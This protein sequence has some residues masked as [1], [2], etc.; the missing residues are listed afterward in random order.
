MWEV[1]WTVLEELI[2]ARREGTVGCRGSRLGHVRA[3]RAPLA[4]GWQVTH[5]GSYVLVVAVRAGQEIRL[6]GAP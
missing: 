4:E 2:S 3:A 1:E 6:C 5:A